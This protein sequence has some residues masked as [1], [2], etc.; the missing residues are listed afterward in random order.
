MAAP[1]HAQAPAGAQDESPV[2]DPG[3]VLSVQKPSFKLP[4]GEAQTIEFDA[5]Q[6]GSYELHCAVMC[7]LGHHG[8]KGEI[9]VDP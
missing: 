6:P 7:G 4:K 3:L 2:I 9:V 1:D 8:M 5:K